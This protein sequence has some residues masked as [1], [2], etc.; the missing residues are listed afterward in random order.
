MSV[1]IVAN[2]GS[3]LVY[4]TQASNRT[5]ASGWDGGPGSSQFAIQQ[6]RLYCSR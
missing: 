1:T 6:V 4:S 3:K 5:D 2:N